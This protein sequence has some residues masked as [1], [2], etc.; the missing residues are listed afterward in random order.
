MYIY[1]FIY[2]STDSI[3]LPSRLSLRNRTGL[4][5]THADAPHEL[6]RH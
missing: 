1:L 4:T 2:L 3:S 6:R 5:H